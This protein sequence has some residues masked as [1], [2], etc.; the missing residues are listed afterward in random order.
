[1][2]GAIADAQ[3]REGGQTIDF[4]YDV[5]WYNAVYAYFYLTD[6]DSRSGAHVMIP[7]SA[8]KKSLGFILGTCTRSE[9]ELAAYYGRGPAPIVIEGRAG[10]GFFE[11]PYCF[12]KALAPISADRLM[13]Q[14]RF[15]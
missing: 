12:H 2:P 8:A 10:F 5:P 1:L 11:D 9:T 7:G 13:L 14:L 6:T 3:R 15:R 4:H